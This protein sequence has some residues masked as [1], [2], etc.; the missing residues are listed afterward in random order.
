MQTISWQMVFGDF[1]FGFALGLLAAVAV[2]T[3]TRMF[4]EERH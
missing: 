2:A 3:I 4:L 1:V